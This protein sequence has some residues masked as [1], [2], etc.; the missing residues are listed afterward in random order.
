MDELENAISSELK[1]DMINIFSTFMEKMDG[2]DNAA[3]YATQLTIEYL[4][5]QT[6][7]KK[8]AADL[9]VKNAGALLKVSLGELDL[10]ARTYN[11][12][13]HNGYKTIGDVVL[14]TEREFL[15]LRNA[16]KHALDD[17]KYRLSEYGLSMADDDFYYR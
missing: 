7:S 5:C 13:H 4:R 15:K 11:V 10:E 9:V 16:G 2:A 14:L 6:K 3:E 8:L 1:N 12:L 17:L